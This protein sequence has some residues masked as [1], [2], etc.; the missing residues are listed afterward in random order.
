ML[1]L[2]GIVIAIFVGYFMKFQSLR[3]L[4]VPYMGETIFKIWYFSLRYIAPVC[5]LL[6]LVK[7]IM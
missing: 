6:V 2:G 5:V 4:F 7:G 3:A 1:P